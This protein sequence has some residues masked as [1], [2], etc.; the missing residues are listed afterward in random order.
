MTG[1]LVNLRRVRK[2]RIRA[3]TETEAAQNR[4]AHG[5]SKAERAIDDAARRKAAH[6]LDLHKREPRKPTE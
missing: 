4:A 3:A 2:D 6:T 5:H 1:D